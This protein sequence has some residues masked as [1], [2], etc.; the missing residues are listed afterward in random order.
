[1]ARDA[2][3]VV[4]DVYRLMRRGNPRE[5]LD[6]ID[7]AATWQGAEGTK[8]KACENGEEVA[9][10]LLWRGTVHRLRATEVIPVGNKVL[11]G[12]VGTRMNRLGAPWWGFKLF[13][14]VSVRDGRIVRIQ[15]FGRREPALAELG[16]RR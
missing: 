10:T 11:V 7:P 5:L 9:K 16:L 2:A 6:L 15:D 13:Q 1:V 14:I 4:Q 12:L 8:W 3:A